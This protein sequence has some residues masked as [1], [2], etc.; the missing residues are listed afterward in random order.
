MKKLIIFLMIFLCAN[1]LNITKGWNLL[2]VDKRID[3]KIFNNAKIIWSYKNHK[4]YY[5]SNEFNIT[6]PKIDVIDNNI[7][8]WLFSEKSYRK[9][10]SLEPLVSWYWQLTGKLKSINAKVYDIDLFDT[11]KSEIEKLKK[12][13]KIVIC[14]FSAG[15]YEDWRS[16]RELF[17]KDEIGKPL[18]GWK[19]EY[20]LDIRSENV[21]NIM[22]KRL[23]LA[24]AKG[25][26]GVETDNVDEYLQDNGFSITYDDQLD[27]NIFLAKEAHKRGLLIALKNDL[28]QINKLVNFFDFAVNEECF[29]YNECDKYLPFFKNK[30]AILNAE[31]KNYS[32]EEKEQICK[33]GKSLGI[34]TI[35]VS[36]EL[37]GSFY[38]SCN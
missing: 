10:I 20:W 15:S 34:S 9:V 30:K 38:E 16:D 4:W 27:Y 33:K 29:E 18:D 26:D 5:Y 1:E 36:K 28:N 32:K 2:G 37:N 7:G 21:R 19:G 31:Y 12:S 11:P 13:G 3:V 25:C 23:D 24:Q 14:Y 6:Y 8:F 17:K 22:K 35:F